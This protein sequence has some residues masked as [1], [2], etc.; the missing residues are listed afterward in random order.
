MSPQTVRHLSFLLKH[1]YWLDFVYPA[2]QYGSSYKKSPKVYFNDLGLRH[3]L[4]RW[5]ALPKESLSMGAVA[6][7]AVFNTLTRL[8]AYD[9]N[10]LW[11]I[12]YWQTYD[13][14]EVD[15]IL[16]MGQ[17]TVGIEVKYQVFK[18]PIVTRGTQNFLRKFK[19]EALL[20][21][22]RQGSF[23]R[24]NPETNTKIVFIPLSEFI[25]LV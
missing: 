12:T 3:A 1:S 17:R 18:K 16:E 7:N 23:Q 10:F 8:C 13:G 2:A 4:L 20:V 5:L 21:I 11:K 24:N 19:P 9:P 15:F 6:E 14:A 22:T 25:R